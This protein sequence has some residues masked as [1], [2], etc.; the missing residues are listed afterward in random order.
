MFTPTEKL[1]RDIGHEAVEDVLEDVLQRAL[2]QVSQ[3]VLRKQNGNFE[4]LSSL[5]CEKGPCHK[6]TISGFSHVYGPLTV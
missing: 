1:P 6:I 4:V 5:W 2:Y 3:P